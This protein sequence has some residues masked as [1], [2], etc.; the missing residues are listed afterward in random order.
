MKRKRKNFTLVEL[1]VSIGVFSVLLVVFMQLFNGLRLAWT[2]TE[3]KND[4]QQSSTISMGII[5]DLLGSIAGVNVEET[6]GGTTKKIPFPFY[7]HRVSGSSD[8]ACNLYFATKAGNRE[9]PGSNQVRFVG[10]VFPHADRNLGVAAEDQN[11]I[12]LTVV[13]NASE[14][15]AGKDISSDNRDVFHKFWP[16]PQFDGYENPAAARQGLRDLLNSKAKAATGNPLPPQ[17]RTELYKNV[18]EFKVKVFNA[19]GSEVEKDKSEVFEMPD[20]LEI[21]VSCLNDADFLIWKNLSGEAR[22]NFQR[23]KQTAYTRRFYIGDR[24]SVGGDYGKY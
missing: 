20:S 10:L 17:Q 15:A 24:W 14:D 23:E 13:S 11:K 4:L 12:Y 3:K 21:T 2:N 9:L 5:S 16:A 6:V 8:A 1:L 22:T 19:S 7:L 18:T